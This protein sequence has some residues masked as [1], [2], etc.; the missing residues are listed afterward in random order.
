VKR[1]RVLLA[2]DHRMMAEGLKRLLDPEFELVGLVEDGRAL[3]EAAA[4]LK[5]DVIVADITM[6]KMNGLE[7]IPLLKKA[8]PN[9]RVVV[10][11]MHRETAY[12]RRALQ[13]GASGYVLKSSAPGELIAAIRAALAGK[14]FVAPEIAGELPSGSG[15]PRKTSGAGGP[16]ASLTTRQREILQLLA[17]GR[18]AKEIAA[19]LDVSARTVEFHKYRMMETLGVRTG[20]ELVRFAVEHDLA[21]H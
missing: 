8:D 11:T 3:L 20:A 4:R 6:P 15:R 12:A 5:P 9:V 14:T 17:A 1:A 18:S 10:I 2:D 21:P 19:I 13:A 7:A 16:V